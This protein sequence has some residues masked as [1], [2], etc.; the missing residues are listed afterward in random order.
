MSEF[1]GGSKSRGDRIRT[2]QFSGRLMRAAEGVLDSGAKSQILRSDTL[3]ELVNLGGAYTALKPIQSSLPSTFF[4][5]TL[6]RN[7]TSDVITSGVQQINSYFRNADLGMIPKIVR[8][9]SQIY[10]DSR[11]YF[12][13][14]NSPFVYTEMSDSQ[15]APAPQIPNFP[16]SVSITRNIEIAR[17]HALNPFWF[18]QQV[19]NGGSWGYKQLDPGTQDRPS[20]YEN[21]G[22]FHYGVMGRAAGIPLAILE[23]EAG[24][25]QIAAGTSMPEWGSPGQY[26]EVWG[27]TGTF[28]DDPNDNYW[29]KKGAEYY[30]S[31]YDK[32]FP[33]KN[34]IE[35]ELDEVFNPAM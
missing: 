32:C 4:L 7:S 1:I 15:C 6:W 11:K 26:G 19:Q 25:A 18:K 34:F 28:G 24:R 31:Y 17:D 33:K 5:I 10:K 22:N 21:F 2:L 29:I 27:G 23:R 16:S 8:D 12:D 30:D 9:Q 14:S 20:P 35:Q 13:F 3:S